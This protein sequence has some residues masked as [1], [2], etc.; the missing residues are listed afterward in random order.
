[1]E[2]KERK[3]EISEYERIN[4]QTGS[5]TNLILDMRGEKRKKR[6]SGIREDEPASAFA[7][8]PHTAYGRKGKKSK[9]KKK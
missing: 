2:G 5:P 6:N 3:K 7:H 1:M 4:K 9:E 8:R